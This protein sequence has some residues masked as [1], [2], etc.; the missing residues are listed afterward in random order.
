MKLLRL[1]YG[2]EKVIYH[3]LRWI[4]RGFSGPL[5]LMAGDQMKYIFEKEIC[6][7]DTLA[8]LT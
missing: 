8:F 4:E 3:I 2:P 5:T 6:S 1:K 7:E